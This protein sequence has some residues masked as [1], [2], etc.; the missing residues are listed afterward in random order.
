M[1]DLTELYQFLKDKTDKE[2]VAL[3]E[4]D[5][6]ELVKKFGPNSDLDFK[7][8]IRLLDNFRHLTE[9]FFRDKFP[10]LIMKESE[11]KGK[12]KL[13]TVKDVALELGVTEVTIYTW[14]KN[15]TITPVTLGEQ[16]KRNIIRFR[17]EEVDR[18]KKG[19]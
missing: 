6:K 14:I 11:K 13:M 9:W 16:G 1:K 10:K 7:S 17:R 4:K 5:S 3:I 8:Q 2:L 19:E 15:K 12:E 18:L